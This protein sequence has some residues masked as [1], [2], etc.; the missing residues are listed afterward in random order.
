VSG[1]VL[2]V[3]VGFY[4]NNAAG[5]HRPSL[6][7]KY[8]PEFGW[9]P[10]AL[11]ADWTPENSAGCYD[12][13]LAARGDPCETIRC[14]Y[15][16]PPT[17]RVGKVWDKGLRW[18][19]PYRYPLRLGR[20]MLPAADAAI[21][22]EHFDAVWSTYRSGLNHY[23]ASRIARKHNI[24]W[25]ADFRDLP[26]QAADSRKAGRIVRAETRACSHAS[27][28]VATTPGQARIL[29]TRYSAP[30]QVIYNGFDPEDCVSGDPHRSDK[31]TIVYSGLIS[32]HRPPQ[33][34]FAALDL[35]RKE[36]AV[37]V[38]DFS[39]RFYGP[40]RSQINALLGR[41][42]CRDVVESHGRVAHDEIMHLQRQAA[43]LLLLKSP[44][45]GESVPLKLFNYLAVGRPILNI[46]GDGGSVDEILD[47]TRAGRSLGDPA[48]IAACLERWYGEWKASGTVSY[49]GIP[50][51]IAKYSRRQQ[52][53][54]LTAILDDITRKRA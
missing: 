37:D 51:K 53:G 27:A 13:Q 9:T 54:Q 24:P 43:I 28:L 5:A 19:Y 35:L 49:D 7:A 17:T 45:A 42:E 38:N 12:P 16:T 10:V 20:I 39:V 4:P 40:P 6:L 36:G 29:R 32:Q 34:L 46:P 22:N 18:A 1:R 52:A 44:E 25:V 41:F 47:E 30:V 21:S 33:P 23:V 8:L 11:C 26:D 14:A 31:F 48:E 2:F 50:A 15:A 3:T